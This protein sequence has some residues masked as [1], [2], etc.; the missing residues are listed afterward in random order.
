MKNRE[1]LMKLADGMYN[2]NR[3]ISWNYIALKKQLQEKTMT[4]LN[5][6]IGEWIKQIREIADNLEGAEDDKNN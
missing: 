1:R 3:H 2:V 6:F 4:D 5:R